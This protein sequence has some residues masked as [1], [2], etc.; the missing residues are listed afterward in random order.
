MNN[1]QCPKGHIQDPLPPA[2]INKSNKVIIANR[3]CAQCGMPI[4][5]IDI[6]QPG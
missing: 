5:Y 6:I 3:I 4:P 1:I 2:V